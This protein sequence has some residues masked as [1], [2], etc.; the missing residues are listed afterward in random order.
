MFPL[1]WI[2]VNGVT[3]DRVSKNTGRGKNIRYCLEKSLC[4]VEIYPQDFSFEVSVSENLDVALAITGHNTPNWGAM[5]LNN[6]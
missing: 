5:Q 6:R 1:C 4:F 2:V 3:Q